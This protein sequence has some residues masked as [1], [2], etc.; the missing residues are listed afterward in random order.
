MCGYLGRISNSEDL[1]TM[2]EE[3]KTPEA[4]EETTDTTVDTAVEVEAPE[5]FEAD[6]DSADEEATA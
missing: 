6:D 1:H 3:V 4:V 5:A 2:E